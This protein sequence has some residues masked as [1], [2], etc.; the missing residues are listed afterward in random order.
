MRQ[1]SI[2][3]QDYMMYERLKEG[4]FKPKVAKITSKGKMKVS[5]VIR[6]R[7]DEDDRYFK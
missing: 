4:K 3:F 1:D 6:E 5:A 2:G 7:E